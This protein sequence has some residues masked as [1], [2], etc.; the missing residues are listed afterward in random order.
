M[1]FQ[2]YEIVVK[3]WYSYLDI[4]LSIMIPYIFVHFIQY[5]IIT[6]Y[7]LCITADNTDSNEIMFILYN[8]DS[9]KLIAMR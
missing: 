7:C 5:H 4:K 6:M 9:M 8:N 2:N 1:K 3:K